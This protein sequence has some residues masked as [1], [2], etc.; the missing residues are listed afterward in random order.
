MEGAH[1]MN[2]YVYYGNQ[3][4]YVVQAESEQEALEMIDCGDA[5][6]E[7]AEILQM[8]TPKLVTTYKDT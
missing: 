5:L 8:E 2:T 1:K 4:I 7:I 3:L 6:D